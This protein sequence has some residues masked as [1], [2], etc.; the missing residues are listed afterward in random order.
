MTTL[1][2]NKA[3]RPSAVQTSR[4]LNNY[5]SEQEVTVS[6]IWLEKEL[7]QFYTNIYPVTDYSELNMKKKT[8]TASS[9]IRG[10]GG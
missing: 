10:G 9:A 4:I 6:F 1:F 8:M 3:M 2:R 5:V 7:L